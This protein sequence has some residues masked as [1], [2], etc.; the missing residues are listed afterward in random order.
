VV[1]GLHWLSDVV[2]GSLLGVLIGGA[3]FLALLR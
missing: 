3:A 2:A 1:L